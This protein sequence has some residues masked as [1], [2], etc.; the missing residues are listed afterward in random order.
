MTL[1]DVY[2]DLVRRG[3]RC[4]SGAYGFECG[5]DAA[6]IKLGDTF[7]VF[8]DD[9]RIVTNAAEME[10]VAHEWAHICEDATYSV[11]APAAIRAIAERK[12]TRFAYEHLAPYQ[13]IRDGLQDQR[14]PAEIAASLNVT[15]A[16]VRDAW[17]FYAA[18]GRRNT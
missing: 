12:A 13:T 10:A 4:F 18:T 7:G 1:T 8:L 17:A 6:T 2:A 9:R 16:F 3:V 14:T 15:E 11:D 5:A